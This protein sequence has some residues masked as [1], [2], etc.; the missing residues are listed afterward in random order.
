ML[1]LS[2][3]QSLVSSNDATYISFSNSIR[4]IAKTLRCWISNFARKGITNGCLSFSPYPCSRS[5]HGWCFQQFEHIYI[6]QW[7]MNPVFMMDKIKTTMLVLCWLAIYDYCCDNRVCVR[8]CHIEKLHLWTSW[9]AHL[10]CSSDVEHFMRH[11]KRCEFKKGKVIDLTPSL[12]CI[13]TSTIRC[14][15]FPHPEYSIHQW[16]L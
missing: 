15:S 9:C 7:F 14:T 13:E 10:P 3:A 11:F 12:L 5:S 1:S 6:Y 16:D 4:L 8:G 2:V